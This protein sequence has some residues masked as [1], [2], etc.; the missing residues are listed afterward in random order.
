MKELAPKNN[1]VNN[2]EE[3]CEHFS[4]HTSDGHCEHSDCVI[5]TIQ[6]G[7]GFFG[8]RYPGR[9]YNLPYIW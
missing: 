6:Y 5:R 7:Y 1:K 3:E 8:G 2:I 9:R 4:F